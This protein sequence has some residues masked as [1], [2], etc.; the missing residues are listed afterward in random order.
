[1]AP[2]M[3][4]LV[5]RLTFGLLVLAAAATEVAAVDT[6][7]VPA[8]LGLA[9]V[10]VGIAAL[11][12]WLVPAPA[13]SRRV[14]PW[15]V[16]FVLLLLAVAPFLVEPLL[17]WW[18]SE[19]NPLELQ[20]VYALRN[21]GLGLAAFAV[22]P[23]C[24]RLACIV[25][26]FLILFAV[27]MTEH[28]AVLWLLGLYSAAGSVWLMLVYW[29]GL[30][31]CFAVP[32]NATLDVAPG[33]PRLPWLATF[34]VMAVLGCV[35]ALVALGPQ[36]AARVLGEWLPTSG[37]TG[38]YDPFARGGV[39]DGDDEIRGDNARTTGNVDSDLFLDSP[40]PS[41]YDIANDL[42]GEPFKPREQERALPLD[43]QTKIRESD[44]PPADNQRPNRDFGTARKGP[45]QPRDAAD[46]AARALFEVEGRTPLH[47]RA[48][49]FDRFDGVSWH[50]APLN[51][52]ACFLDAERGSPWMQV[53]ERTPPPIFA[54]NDWHRFKITTS[55]GSLVPTPPHLV[56]FRVGRVD[57]ANFF[58]LGP[59]RI[60]RMADRK[61]PAGITVQT[62]SRSV[63]PRRLGSVHFPEGVVGDRPEYA[64]VP[65]NLDPSVAELARR[66]TEG[67]PRGWEQIA[68]VVRRLR[69][70]Y[71][72]DPLAHT[73]PDCSEP[74]SHFLFQ[75]RRGPDYQFASA[76][77]CLL[78]V[79]GYPTRLVSGFYVSPEQYD[80]L[81]R[82]TPVVREDLHFWAEV[83]LPAGDWLVVE[84]TPGYEV[85]GP[86][87]PWSERLW[88]ALCTVGGWLGDHALAV[89]LGTVV[90]A[91]GWWQRRWLVDRI[92]L[93]LLQAFPGP[94][95]QR[96]VRRV[97]WLLE[98]RGQWAG[99]PRPLSQTQAAW[100]MGMLRSPGAEIDSELRQ[101]ARMA[102]W[103]SYGTD[104]S[105]PWPE[106]QVETV[107]R[108][109]L[110]VWTLQR[111]RSA[112]AANQGEDR[113]D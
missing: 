99:C 66:W 27:T 16:F 30:R 15:S 45:R 60:L 84:P 107:C 113:R 57:Q 62:E 109:V 46:R 72:H 34:L 42:Y 44:K 100:L 33:R 32:E 21:L 29:S 36:G 8:S 71:L 89:S 68:A 69:E 94:S 78:R 23:L 83:L 105:P 26:L 49:V 40:L 1:M 9:A 38:A 48:A 58:A 52:A 39:N 76:A 97:L 63:D 20:M 28:P 59:E 43:A 104:L 65:A 110:D 88:T 6:R 70:D 47:I 53:R 86:N 95:W 61:A 18:T 79:L 108:R 55:F 103:S 22:W 31:R 11:C 112:T 87:L 75:A 14:P 25:S 96:R 102:E 77:A 56:R 19:G 98:R 91:L 4:G 73:P 85:L 24:L 82:H 80:P 17:R 93:L 64:L 54:V 10:W 7:P 101:L 81:T 2:E 35:L 67:L 13:D 12:G 111:W 41:L 106:A 92:A 51:P 74:L 3:S 50:E 90:L 37:G 5:R